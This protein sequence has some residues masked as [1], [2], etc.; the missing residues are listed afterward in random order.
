MLF[1][2]RLRVLRHP[3]VL[4]FLSSYASEETIYLLTELVSPL[5]VVIKTLGHD[6]AIKGFRDVARGLQFLHEKVSKICL[7]Q[8][9]SLSCNFH[10]PHAVW[11]F[12]SH[13]RH[14]YHT[15]TCILVISLCVRQHGAGRLEALSVHWS[16]SV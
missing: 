11:D 12:C 6:E 4:K 5:E 1:L 15:I 7:L 3:N 13:N 2:K 14:C 9:S 8:F 10:N 16:L